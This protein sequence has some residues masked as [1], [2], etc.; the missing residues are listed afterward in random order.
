[1]KDGK[2]RY[3]RLES[4]NLLDYVLLG[5]K[6]EIVAHSMGRTLNISAKGIMLE[7]HLPCTPGQHLLITIGLEEDLVDIKGKVKHAEQQ[8]E[9][10]F[11]AGIEF[12]EIDD[13]GNRVLLN[14]LKAFESFKG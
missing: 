5:D 7:T 12:V 2:R 11:R 10:I 13:E 4:L 6:G 9:K 8:D 1:M 14:Y 3:V